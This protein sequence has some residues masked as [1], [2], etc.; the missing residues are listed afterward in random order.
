MSDK[1]F[2]L[3]KKYETKLMLLKEELAS[4]LSDPK[5]WSRLR[6]EIEIFEEILHDLKNDNIL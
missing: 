1:S 4:D 6:M 2:Y 3:E 5:D